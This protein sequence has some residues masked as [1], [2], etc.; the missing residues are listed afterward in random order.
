VRF[1]W[2]RRRRRESELDEE[3]RGHLAM[4]ARNRVESGRAPA[5]AAA[6]ARREF[7]NVALV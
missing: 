4:A 6:E 1:G 3:I 2:L 5:D 7:D